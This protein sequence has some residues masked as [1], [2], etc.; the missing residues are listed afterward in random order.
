MKQL[1]TLIEDVAGEC[2]SS[3]F[4]LWSQT[5]V[6]DYWEHASSETCTEVLDG[7]RDG[8]VPGAT[9]MAPA[10]GQLCGLGDVPL[11]AHRDGHSL[12][13]SGHVAWASHL[14]DGAVVVAPVRV[15][16]EGAAERWVIA[17]RVGAPGVTLHPA[18]SL[19]ALNGTGS[20]SLT[21]ADVVVHV[22][23]ILSTDMAGFVSEVRPRLLLAQSAMCAGLARRS[24]N[25]ARARTAVWDS[26]LRTVADARLADVAAV[27]DGVLHRLDDWSDRSAEIEIAALMQLRLDAAAVAAR[28]T[29]LE[30]LV[31]GGA[32]FLSTSATSR[33]LREAAFLP[34]QAPTEL[35]L[36][37]QLS[38][39]G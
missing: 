36:L 19:L 24:V 37:R 29:D 5:A 3:A 23:R 35:Q 1:L 14:W 21:L 32:G 7:L 30:V 39:S 2:L 31:S 28:A 26:P 16:E 8:T 4:S 20:S 9:A 13:V 34:I 38:A 10:L 15:P 22:D 17:F 6:I 27:A 25:E 18:P 12:S 11:V 33:R